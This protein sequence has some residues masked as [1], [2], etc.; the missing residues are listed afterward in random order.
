MLLGE[1]V[2]LRA[3]QIE[4]ADNFAL[5]QHGDG[6]LGAR[7]WIHQ[8][9][10]VVNG[11]IGNEDGFTQGCGSANDAFAGSNAQLSLN[12]LAVLDVEAVT[13]HFLLFVVQ[14]DADNLVVNHAL[15]KFGG[16]AQK[17]LDIKDGAD[18][19]A[20]FREDHESFALGAL[21]L[22]EARVL[23]GDGEAAGQQ[24]ENVLLVL[25]EVVRLAALDI[26]DTN[27]GAA[28]HEWH[29]QFRTNRVNGIDVARV[30]RHVADTDRMTSSSG[31]AGN[32]LADGHPEVL[33]QA[34][35]IANG[36]TM[37]QAIAVAVDHKHAKKLVVDVTLDERRSVGQDLVEV[38][39]SV[40]FFA[41]FRESGEHL[42]GHF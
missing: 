18:L 4:D 39:R 1:V 35:R 41:D 22:E 29:G 32:S 12:A 31:G 38:K 17:F 42:G 15:H 24:R 25:G 19:T 6:K 26:K 28:E 3:F 13:K 34:R 36:K 5:V 33:S 8:Q 7:L 23:N 27:A 2:E 9:V 14:H 21:F 40:H 16:A 20:D 10:A 37:A 30:L 11:D